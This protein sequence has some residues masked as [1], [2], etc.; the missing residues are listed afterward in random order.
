MHVHP[1]A[2]A[3]AVKFSEAN[4]GRYTSLN[5]YV[6][7]HDHTLLVLCPSEQ[8]YFTIHVM[9]NHTL[10]VLYALVFMNIHTLRVMLCLQSYILQHFTGVSCPHAFA[11]PRV[12]ASYVLMQK[13]AF[14]ES[15]SPDTQV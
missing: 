13:H 10:L 11:E 2:H 14:L 9:H 3:D 12:L 6:L 4:T 1:Q 8:P 15:L 7:L 5:Y